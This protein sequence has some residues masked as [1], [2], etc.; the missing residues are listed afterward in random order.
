MLEADAVLPTGLIHKYPSCNKLLVQAASLTGV[1][2]P[3]MA[4]T[5]HVYD[6]LHARRPC[7]L[8]L[9]TTQPLHSGPMV[10]GGDAV[11]VSMHEP[12]SAVVQPALCGITDIQG[13]SVA[14][15]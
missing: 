8:D 1:T 3:C 10:G 7:F 9:R 12:G 4:F 5:T 11:R 14:G 6:P 2:G 15:S 13:Y